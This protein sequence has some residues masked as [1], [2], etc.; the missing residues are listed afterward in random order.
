[1]PQV[2]RP[3]L[4]ECRDL[5]E[6]SLS[7]I[8]RQSAKT[9]DF[10]G[11][12]PTLG[13]FSG[14]HEPSLIPEVPSTR[15]TSVVPHRQITNLSGGQNGIDRPFKSLGRRP[16]LHQL[17]RRYSRWS[18]PLNWILYEGYCCAQPH[19]PDRLVEHTILAV[20]SAPLPM[21]RVGP[22]H[23]FGIAQTDPHVCRGQSRRIEVLFVLISKNR[24]C[25]L[26]FIANYY[27]HR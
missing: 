18:F 15:K 17:V 10:L 5:V 21:K 24:L 16:K 26:D 9:D 12:G 25:R 11:W 27:F 20:P 22:H 7:A 19:C 6:S 14:G 4:P 1:M 3:L 8:E 23:L 13:R 2:E